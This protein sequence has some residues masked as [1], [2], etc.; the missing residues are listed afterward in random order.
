MAEDLEEDFDTD[1]DD[2]TSHSSEKSRINPL[3][4]LFHG[5]SVEHSLDLLVC[6]YQL[7]KLAKTKGD[8]ALELHVERPENS[9]YFNRY[10]LT[11]LERE[12][13]CDLLRLLTLGTSDGNHMARMHA[14][15]ISAMRIIRPWYRARF[16]AIAMAVSAHCDGYAPQVSI[17]M[18]RC[19]LPLYNRP[20]FVEMENALCNSW[21]P[22]WR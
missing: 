11:D 4:L 20:T 14:A 12:F 15:D 22:D 8:L 16:S 9:S 1:E 10:T 3:K 21:N 13:I 7:F 6:L 18:A 5:L 2:I 19:V 17:E